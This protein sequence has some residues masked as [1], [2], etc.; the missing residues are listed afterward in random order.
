M[1]E[2]FINIFNKRLRS[3]EGYDSD[4]LAKQIKREND[5]ETRQSKAKAA[6]EAK[7]HSVTLRRSAALDL[8]RSK[9]LQHE[10]G[11]IPTFT[12]LL[13][14]VHKILNKADPISEDMIRV[15]VPYIVSIFES[16]LKAPV[17]VEVYIRLALLKPRK[18]F[19]VRAIFNALSSQIFHQVFQSAA[20]GLASHALVDNILAMPLAI[21]PQQLA[22]YESNRPTLPAPPPVYQQFQQLEPEVGSAHIDDKVSTLVQPPVMEE[23]AVAKQ[24][25]D[26]CSLSSSILLIDLISDAEHVANVFKAAQY[27]STALWLDQVPVPCLQEDFPAAKYLMDVGTSS[28]GAQSLSTAKAYFCHL[29]PKGQTES[30]DCFTE[31]M[32]NN[33]RI[34]S[35]G[36][37]TQNLSPYGCR[38]CFGKWLSRAE[39]F[40]HF[41]SSSECVIGS[42]PVSS[43]RWD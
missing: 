29:C 18:K 19:F 43:D 11:Q 40:D 12:V 24:L 36:E 10:D 25:E 14:R 39:L 15:I 9:T 28:Q 6:K 35:T 17:D 8:I 30:V 20:P 26:V 5:G 42:V 38:Y 34:I 16:H 31:H 32:L 27:P 23:H 2:V 7:R 13:D 3:E 21:G 37:I 33:H 41:M 4:R 1:M 22:Y